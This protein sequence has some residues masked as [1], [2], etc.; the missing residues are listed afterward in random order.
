MLCYSVALKCVVR[1]ARENKCPIIWFK[2]MTIAI[3]PLG[4]PRPQITAWLFTC[5]SPPQAFDH[6]FILSL[7]SGG[8]GGAPHHKTQSTLYMYIHKYIGDEWTNKYISRK[9]TDAARR[10]QSHK[11]HQ[12]VSDDGPAELICIVLL[13][14]FGLSLTY[15]YNCATI[16]LCVFVHLYYNTIIAAAATTTNA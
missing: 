1:I 16:S 13:F 14:R 9:Y 15:I 2:M 8:G 10:T 4:C 3:A 12:L 11:L 5:A 7:Y 6:C